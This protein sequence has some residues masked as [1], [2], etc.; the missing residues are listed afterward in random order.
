MTIEKK[1][2]I[3]IDKYEKGTRITDLAA[4]YCMTKSTVATILKNKE[5]IKGTDVMMGVKSNLN[6]QQQ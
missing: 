1:K 2:K 3:D 6:D 5:A 4:D